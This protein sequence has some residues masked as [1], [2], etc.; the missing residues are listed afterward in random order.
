MCSET[1]H[2]QISHCGNIGRQAE[3]RVLRQQLQTLLA[4]IHPSHI[5]RGIVTSVVATVGC[6]TLRACF[7]PRRFKQEDRDLIIVD[8]SGRNKQSDA[9]FEEM[10]QVASAVEADIIIFVMDSSIGQAAHDQ[11]Q[12]FKDSVK[13]PPPFLAIQRLGK[14]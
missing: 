7:S 13:V 9:L 14:I 4:D 6:D 1:G 12:A 10:R 8:T 3:G 5:L 11:A 2:T